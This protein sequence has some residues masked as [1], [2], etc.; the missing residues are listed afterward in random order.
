MFIKGETNMNNKIW[1]WF[2][3]NEYRITKQMEHLFLIEVS[4]GDNQWHTL[5]V[6]VTLKAA[7]NLILNYELI[8]SLERASA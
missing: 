4:F 3:H 5:D 7:N 1:G 8:Q 2:T 6:A